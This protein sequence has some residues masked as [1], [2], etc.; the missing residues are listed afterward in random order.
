MGFITNTHSVTVQTF[1]LQC[2]IAM[3]NTFLS[4]W[5][6]FRLFQCFAFYTLHCNKTKL[7]RHFRFYIF[8][9]FCFHKI[10]NILF[11]W[12]EIL[13]LFSCEENRHTPYNVVYYAI[14][15]VFICYL[16]TNKCNDINLHFHQPL[17]WNKSILK[18]TLL[19]LHNIVYITHIFNIFPHYFDRTP[20]TIH[21]S[22]HQCTVNPALQTKLIFIFLFLRF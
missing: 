14:I 6:Q 5:F 22:V 21:L 8:Y 13:S 7:Y 10:F 2:F 11:F 3:I 18:Y 20:Y 16:H 12:S 17:F 19:T 9:Y 1:T 15:K 4:H